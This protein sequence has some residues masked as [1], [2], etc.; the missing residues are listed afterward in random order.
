MNNS[1]TGLKCG[2]S[3]RVFVAKGKNK[4]AREPI[5]LEWGLTETDGNHPCL[6]MSM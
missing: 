6:K 5:Y 4:G 3:E 1:L 2:W